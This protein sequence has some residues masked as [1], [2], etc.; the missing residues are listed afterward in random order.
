MPIAN[1]DKDVSEKRRIISYDLGAVLTGS[2]TLLNIVA[3]QSKIVG[4]MS[5]VA[6]VSGTPVYSLW[7]YRFNVGLG[8][9]SMVLGSTISMSAYGTS[10]AQT[11]SVSAAGVTNPLQA[12][13][14]LVLFAQGANSAVTQCVVGLAIEALQ[15]FQTAYGA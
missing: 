12:G 5:A 7:L 9:T 10:G 11:F 6:G 3:N 8:L 1:R 4:A 14:A 13:D 15:D 2:T